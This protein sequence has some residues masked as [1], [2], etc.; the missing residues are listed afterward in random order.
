MLLPN[1]LLIDLWGKC[2]FCVF[3]LLSSLLIY[4]ILLQDNTKEKTALLCVQLWLLNP[5]TMTVSSRGNAESLLATLVLLSLYC[6]RKRASWL[7]LG[8]VIYGLSVH[9]KIYP[10]TYSLPIYLYM[11]N[12]SDYADNKQEDEL[13][14][15]KKIF[16]FFRMLW[17]NMSTLKFVL[18][19][20]AVF[21]ASTGLCY[22]M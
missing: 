22:Y 6:L 15:S 11:Q 5:L 8:A 9:M 7:V 13:T 2:L 14:F 10:I 4:A 1:V 21:V 19:S 18:I 17:P 20:V 3:D 12:S 16:R